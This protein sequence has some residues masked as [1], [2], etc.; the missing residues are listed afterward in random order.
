M[1]DRYI[2]QVR[3]L[4]SVLPDV[5]EEKT[6]ALKGGTAINLFYRD[7]PRLSVDVD[8]TY[9]PIRDRKTSLGDIDV[10]FDRIAHMI[11]KR[12]PN[13]KARREL[14][15]GNHK[16]RISVSHNHIKIK[17]EISPVMR[18]TVL[19]PITMSTSDV[20]VERFGFAEANV[21]AFED[22]FGSKL[23]AAVDRQHPR[24]LF[25]V[26]LLFENE[27][28][29]DDLFRV[30]LVYVAG[31]S[32]PLHDVLAPNAIFEDSLYETQFAGMTAE[33][34]TKDQLVATQERLKEAI[35][36]RLTGKVSTFLLS[37]H[38]GDPN[39]ELIDLPD[40]IR[41]P[42][43]QWK[44]QNLRKLKKENST[45]HAEQRATLEKLLR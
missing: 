22:L 3:L 42:A 9:V 6:L 24:D 20:V 5:A 10:T 38:D 33:V 25:D 31:S 26:M 2:D 43:I 17:I 29:S 40:A 15:I 11:Q 39:F 45:K 32:R 44:L 14:G 23:H 13:L 12:N 1:D 8:L 37:L 4:L 28:F 34:V 30:F 41:L 7:L 19:S 27:G 35:A 16:T 36:S 18:G 21:L